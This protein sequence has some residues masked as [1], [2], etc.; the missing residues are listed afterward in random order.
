MNFLRALFWIVLT[1]VIVVFSMR[2]WTVVPVSLFGGLVAYAKLPV[3]L[4]VTFLLGWAPTYGW[5]RW[6]RW[7]LERQLAATSR[8]PAP[9]W[10]VKNSSPSFTPPA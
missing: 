8:T 2:N 7:R 1:V 9:P 10:A 5:Y 6:L 3:L 4:F